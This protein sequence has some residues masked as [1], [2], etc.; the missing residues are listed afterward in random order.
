ME[1]VVLALVAVVSVAGCSSLLTTY[2]HLDAPVGV[3]RLETCSSGGPPVLARYERKGA[4][5]DVTMEPRA[6]VSSERG[7]LRVRAP[8]GVAVT[9]PEPFGYVRL[10]AG[11]PPIRFTL[12]QGEARRLDG[13]VE[14]R[15]E[16]EGLPERIDFAGTLHLPEVLVGNERVISPVFQFHREGFAGAPPG[17]C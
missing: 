5:F 10:D 6:S 8:E 14:R 1:R 4:T 2:V 17:I 12:H 16:F 3:M 15:F 11:G 13:V 7:F 9:M